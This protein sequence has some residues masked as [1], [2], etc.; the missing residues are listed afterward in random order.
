MWAWLA[1]I[2][3]LEDQVSCMI[4]MLVKLHV[5]WIHKHTPW[6]DHVLTFLHFDGI[7]FSGYVIKMNERGLFTCSDL[8][9]DFFKQE[10]ILGLGSNFLT[11]SVRKHSNKQQLEEASVC[12]ATLYKYS[13]SEARVETWRQ[14]LKQRPW[15]HAAHWLG[16]NDNL[17]SIINQENA[18]KPIW[19]WQ[20]LNEHALFINQACV[21]LTK[22]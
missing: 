7:C 10:S 18:H 11:V 4:P 6:K 21:K 13:P 16:P 5:Y 8:R 14:E 20:L 3:I 22:T 19:W 12:L 2:R 1:G 15:G 9:S 17:T